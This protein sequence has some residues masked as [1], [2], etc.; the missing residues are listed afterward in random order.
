M[1]LWI[2]RKKEREKGTLRREE[3]MEERATNSNRMFHFVKKEKEEREEESRE[4]IESGFQM[5]ELLHTLR[6]KYIFVILHNLF[7]SFH[8][9]ALFNINP[10]TWWRET[11]RKKENRRKRE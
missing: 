7:P 3:R 11:E 6:N 8:S 4:K 5:H 10:E 2:E 1:D 9:C